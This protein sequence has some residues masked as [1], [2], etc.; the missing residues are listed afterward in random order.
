MEL[1]L[2]TFEA[3]LAAADDAD[4]EFRE[5]DLHSTDPGSVSR[6]V[7]CPGAPN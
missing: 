4:K 7:S 1:M 5:T 6:S 2:L 3:T